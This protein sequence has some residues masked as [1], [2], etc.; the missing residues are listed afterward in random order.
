MSRNVLVTGATGAVGS[1]I[2]RC[3]A[4]ETG[5]C[6]SE[7]SARGSSTAVPWRLGVEAPPAALLRNWDVIVHVA[8]STRWTMT[9]EEAEAAN[10]ASTRAI[11]EITSQST[12][13]VHISTAFACPSKGPDASD[14]ANYRNHYEWSK[15]QS[16]ALVLSSGIDAVI[17]RPPLIIGRRS[18]GHI[19]R[20]AGF[21]TLLKGIMTGSMP[22]VVGE[23]AAFLELVTTC[24]V[25]STVRNVLQSPYQRTGRILTMGR[26]TGALDAKSTLDV[27]INTM[28]SWRGDHSL[29]PVDSPRFVSMDSWNRFYRPFSESVLSSKRLRAID[30]LSEFHSYASIT[31][32]IPINIEVDDM[33]TS[34][35]S[36]TIYWLDSH[37]R[38]ASKTPTP[39]T[40]RS[41]ATGGD[42]DRN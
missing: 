32:P 23:P 15:R 4:S 40:S 9:A 18:D 33:V 38:I 8:A 11:L 27:V 26:G 1:Q 5:W 3:L 22:V 7:T 25:A 37:P 35:A 39:W 20:F 29:K 13:F 30:L 42:R 36:S 41:V 17:V 19:D 16:E 14:P 6:V 34:I 21:Y 10:V 2:V 24:D 28:N 31:E 12:Y